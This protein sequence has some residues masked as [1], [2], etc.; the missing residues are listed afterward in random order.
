MLP[1]LE[2]SVTISYDQC[3]HNLQNKMAALEAS[4][5]PVKIVFVTISLSSQRK[6]FAEMFKRIMLLRCLIKI[7]LASYSSKCYRG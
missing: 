1:T 4:V 2:V 7:L 5:N 6:L 3:R